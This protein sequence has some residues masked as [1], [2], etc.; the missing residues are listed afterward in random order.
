MEAAGSLTG[1]CLRWP[2]TADAGP[3]PDS[4]PQSG[5]RWCKVVQLGAQRALLHLATTDRCATVLLVYT[6]LKTSLATHWRGAAG[7]PLLR[8][9]CSPVQVGLTL[10]SQHSTTPPSKE[11]TPV[12]PGQ[13]HRRAWR[14]LCPEC[15][16]RLRSRSLLPLR[17]RS[18]L[19]TPATR[20]MSGSP[21]HQEH[22][23][24]SEADA[25]LQSSYTRTRED[26]L[27][28]GNGWPWRACGCRCGGRHAGRGR[29]CRAR[30]RA[31]GCDPGAPCR[32]R[33]SS[34]ESGATTYTDP[35]SG[36]RSLLHT[37]PRPH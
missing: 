37:R 6:Q 4:L 9:P 32:V 11:A 28:P 31:R 16:A 21:Q 7:Y 33:P 18:R 8:P 12:A 22:H 26:P 3:W 15:R 1:A 20:A 23:S 5:A 10:H 24:C 17:L 34:R 25:T 19:L 30:A 35:K 2:H 36:R 14:W 29:A 27:K 13:H